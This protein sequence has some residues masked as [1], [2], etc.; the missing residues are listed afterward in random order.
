MSRTT[1]TELT[2]RRQRPE[3]GKRLELRDAQARGLVLVIEQSGVKTWLWVRA[4]NGV[5]HKITLGTWPALSLAGARAQAEILAGKMAA[6]TLSRR[7]PRRE[8]VQG[9]RTVEAMKRAFIDDY[10]ASKK[11]WRNVEQDL[12][13]HAMPLLGRKRPDKVSRTDIGDVLIE[14]EEMP[15]VHNK[16]KSHLSGLFRW[17]ARPGIGLVPANP[18]VGF[19][20]LPTASR[21]HV[22]RDAEL[23]ALWRA[24]GA[25]G[26]PYGPWCKLMILLGQRRTETARMRR[27]LTGEV[28][29]IP[30]ADTKNGRVH[31]V[32]LPPAARAI[33]AGL[34]VRSDGEGG[35]SPFWFPAATRPERA[36]STFS[37]AK[38]ALDA[39]S[40]VTGWW[41]HDLRRTMT[42]NMAAL[43]IPTIV[44][45]AV[46]NHVSGEKAGVAGTYNRYE[47][48]EEKRAALTAW[49]ERLARITGEG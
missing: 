47:Y 28:W 27:A 32:P 19:E 7:R 40:G 22:L 8:K 3:P 20:T 24:C 6:G 15:R 30:A 17:A 5:R 23:A 13:N 1:L 35:E 25:V 2:V 14:L 9:I 45:E 11:S 43:G 4:K 37:D 44:R 39:A 18:V 38:A 29:E 49:A 46:T 36:M 16:V 41:F 12:D 42:T 31:L 10:K 26:Y 34:P 21:D 48:V 33:L